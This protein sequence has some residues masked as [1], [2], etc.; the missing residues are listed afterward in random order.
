[1]QKLKTVIL[2]NALFIFLLSAAILLSAC[3]QETTA[4][5]QILASGELVVITRNSPATYFQDE[6]G[7]TGFEYEL[8]KRFADHLGVRLRIETQDNIDAIYQRLEMYDSQQPVL[9]AAGLISTPDRD[10]YIAFSQGYYSVTPKVIYHKSAKLPRKVE[11]LI[12]KRILV[13][14]GSYQ[15]YLLQQLQKD[16]PELIFE[17]SDAI[18]SV[19]LLRLVNDKQIDI[20]IINSNE[21][22]INQ[23][24]FANVRHAFDISP[25]QEQRWAVFR[26][27][28]NTLLQAA[29]SFITEIQASGLMERLAQR[30]YGHIEQMGYVG[31]YAFAQDLQQRLPK[32]EKYFKQTA[33]EY[34]MDWR[35]LAAIGYQESHWQPE[36][37]SKTGVRGLMMLT[38]N[39]AKAMGISNRLDPEQSI[40]G[41][42]RVIETLRN[43]KALK[44]IPEPDQTWLVLA[45]YNVGLGHLKDAQQLAKQEGLNPEKWNDVRKMLPRLSQKEWYSKTRYGYARGGEPVHFVNNI[46]RY[47]DILTWVTQPQLESNNLG[48]TMLHKPQIA[49]ELSTTSQDEQAIL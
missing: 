2:S 13:M 21:L 24:Y 25:A 15:A 30:Y 36:A 20:S 7:D 11:D 26:S 27:D 22:A 4:L 5:Q 17:T 41:A 35:L 8:V 43:D 23:V 12:G 37:T 31:A 39:T 49:P 29:N 47:Y 32:Y 9:A 1:M 48:N 6:N 28:D 46:R 42:A 45:S 33:Q 44:D 40:L 14:K 38:N 18:E 3:R 34:T 19:D 16:H 10:E